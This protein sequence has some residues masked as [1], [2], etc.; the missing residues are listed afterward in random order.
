[1][2]DETKEEKWPEHAGVYD[3]IFGDC[4][5]H[6]SFCLER[7]QTICRKNDE[8][9]RRCDKFTHAK[10]EEIILNLIHIQE[11]PELHRL[12][13]FDASAKTLSQLI[14]W[15]ITPQG[16]QYWSDVNKALMGVKYL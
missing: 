1:M 2:R 14:L 9:I 3:Y 15:G 5:S 4:G 6:C 13:D 12:C 7:P 16:A 8:Q 11:N 10:K